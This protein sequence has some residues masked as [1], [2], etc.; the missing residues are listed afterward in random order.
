MVDA[1]WSDLHLLA[2]RVV[3]LDASIREVDGGPAR[4]S[5]LDPRAVRVTRSAARCSCPSGCPS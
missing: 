3:L 4:I 2:I 1:T 5:R